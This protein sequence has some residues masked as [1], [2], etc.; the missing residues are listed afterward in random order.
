[1][2]RDFDTVVNRS[3]LRA[4]KGA[5]SYH[6]SCGIA[7]ALLPLAGQPDLAHIMAIPPFTCKVC[8]VT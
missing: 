4:R 2:W 3:P 1:M 7:N 5:A 6:S 8:P